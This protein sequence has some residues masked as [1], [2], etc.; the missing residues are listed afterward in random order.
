MLIFIFLL[1]I[2]ILFFKL[3]FNKNN[4]NDPILINKIYYIN[5][6]K[7]LNRKKTLLSNAKNENLKL[8]RFPGVN[9]KDL[10]LEELYKKKNIH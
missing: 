3:F 9:G 10:D 7:S 1:L 8:E 4:N 5:L 6:E 2:L